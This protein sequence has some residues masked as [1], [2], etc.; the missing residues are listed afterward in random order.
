MVERCILHKA[1]HLGPTKKSDYAD[2]SLFYKNKMKVFRKDLLQISSFITCCTPFRTYKEGKHDG[3]ILRRL[4]KRD[5]ECKDGDL[6]SCN[7]HEHGWS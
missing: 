7:V 4:P 2:H 5:E 1:P 3:E 6:G